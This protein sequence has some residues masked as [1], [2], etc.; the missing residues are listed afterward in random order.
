M[1]TC[2]YFSVT[3]FL[4]APAITSGRS[5]NSTSPDKTAP[6]EENKAVAKRF[7]NDLRNSNPSFCKWKVC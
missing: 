5:E 4:F 6:I 3:S 7:F 2:G 1:K